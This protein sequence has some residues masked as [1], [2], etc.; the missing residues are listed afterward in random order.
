MI[1]IKIDVSDSKQA[2][3]CLFNDLWLHDY[4]I[5]PYGDDFENMCMLAASAL[6]ERYEVKNTPLWKQAQ[7]MVTDLEARL[8]S[9]S[10]GERSKDEIS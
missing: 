7:E 1:R 3:V 9:L 8:N 2:R 10:F 4:E 6:K 5:I